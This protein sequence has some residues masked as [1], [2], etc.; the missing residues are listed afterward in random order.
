MGVLKPVRANG[1][2]ARDDGRRQA[3]TR[4]GFESALRARRAPARVSLNSCR[5]PRCQFGLSSSHPSLS[6]SQYC[7]ARHTSGLHRLRSP[8]AGKLCQ[9]HFHC[10]FSVRNPRLLPPASYQCCTP[11]SSGRCEL[12]GCRYALEA[13]NAR[14]ELSGLGGCDRGY[15]WT[16]GEKCIRA[17]CQR[18]VVDGHILGGYAMFARI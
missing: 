10:P 12:K 2:P 18:S 6:A 14:G 8:E 16:T 15:W 4:R 3:R 1:V 17:D 13:I 9:R 7:R 11:A 5:V